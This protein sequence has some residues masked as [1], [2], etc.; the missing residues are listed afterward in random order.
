MYPEAYCHNLRQ[1]T[2]P[3]LSIAY[4]NFMLSM[5]TELSEMYCR[6]PFFEGYKFREKSKSTFL[7]KLF[8]RINISTRAATYMIMINSCIL[9]YISV[10]QFL[11]KAENLRNP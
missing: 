8:S 6:V 7:W 11:S 4:M 5:E 9:C 10:K 1:L 3:H 2:K